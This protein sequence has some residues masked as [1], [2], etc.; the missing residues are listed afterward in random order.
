MAINDGGGGGDDDDDD[1]VMV[2]VVV[3]RERERES[4]SILP[5][6]NEQHILFIPAP[7]ITNINPAYIHLRKLVGM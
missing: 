5:E 2:V 6:R 4:K 7:S 1:V 3:V